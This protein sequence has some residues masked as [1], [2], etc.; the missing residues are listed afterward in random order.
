MVELKVWLSFVAITIV[1]CVF[2][3]CALR[4]PMRQLLEANSYIIPAKRFYLRAF[5]VLIFL[6][7]LAIIS[8]TDCPGSDA[9]FMEYVW[10]VVGKLQPLFMALSFWLIGYAAMLT[11]LFVVLGRYR[12]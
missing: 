9:V 1:V 6:V 3:I 12:D 2:L 5:S 10:W 7:A 11:L 8:E 4:K